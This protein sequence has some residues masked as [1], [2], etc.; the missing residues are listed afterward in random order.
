MVHRSLVFSSVA[1][2]ALLA[3][4]AASAADCS[5]IE[6]N[7]VV[8][9]GFNDT[10]ELADWGESVGSATISP[11]AGE[12][13]AAA[14]VVSEPS[15]QEHVIQLQSQ[16]FAVN[17]GEELHQQY[18]ARRIAGSGVSCRAGFQH[19]TG[20]NCTGG[21]AGG[22]IG[23]NPTTIGT[24][25]VDVADSFQVPANAASTQFQLNCRSAAP[26]TVDVDNVGA[27]DCPIDALC[28][29][30]G[31]FTVT[32]EFRAVNGL[33]GEAVSRKLSEQSGTFFYLN[34]DNAEFL[35]KVID[36][37]A[38]NQHFWAFFAATTNAEF[39]VRVTDTTT[40]Q[41]RTY[42]NP[43]GQ[44]ALPVQDTQAFATCAN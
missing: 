21:G 18:S 42:S 10:G 14:R 23:F 27:R 36:G 15:G 8:S 25:F 7:R 32:V 5:L 34:P 3:I 35:V 33:T 24:S 43:L 44:A 22:S 17:P 39:T 19:L 4:P 28:L 9:C 13:G 37:C 30:D 29:R 41:Q 40:G 6:G 38:I 20:A 31:R 26:F 12:N 2:A 1:L 16:C 11:A